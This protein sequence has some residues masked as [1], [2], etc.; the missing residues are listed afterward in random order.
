M[1]TAFEFPKIHTFIPFYTKQPNA[2]VLNN[3]LDSWCEILLNYCQHYKITSMSPLT[4]KIIH[5]QL[6]DDDIKDIPPLFENKE[7][8]RVANDEFKTLI[9]KHLILIQ[10]KAELK[11]PK[12]PESGVF[13]YWRSLAEW[14]QVVYSFAQ[15]TGQLG[16]VLTLYE[17]TKLTD[18]GLTDDIR[19]LEYDV[20]VK[21]L[22]LL[23]KQGKAQILMA[24][25][26]HEIGGVKI[27]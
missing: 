24:E 26:G 11:N 16:S 9:F 19:N 6:E 23:V 10:N 12:S 17:L 14:A 15:K 1:T 22:K 13:V 4:G 21:A 2:T 8:K 5:S 27:V 25:D 3:Q 7:I 20:L 18:S